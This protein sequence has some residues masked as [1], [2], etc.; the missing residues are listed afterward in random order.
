[1]V[2]IFEAAGGMA[3]MRRLSAA[4]HERA[5][6][7]P[8]VGHAFSHG[9]RDDHVERLAAYLGE[10]LGGPASYSERYGTESDVLR[11]H[12]GTGVHEEM[13]A[14][15]IDLFNDAVDHCGL[16]DDPPLRSAIKAY[17]AW[18]TRTTMAA[19]PESAD[20][21]PAGMSIPQWSWEGPTPA[22]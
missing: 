2:T 22:H 3:A 16:P 14:E 13:D 18:A 10:A 1:M 7:A 21:V 4:W 9:F 17:W 20:D 11:L 8:I 6:V 12:S 5:A 19:F 15:A